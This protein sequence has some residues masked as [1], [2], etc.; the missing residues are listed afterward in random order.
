MKIILLI[1]AYIFIGCLVTFA[2]SKTEWF[3]DIEFAGNAE[4]LVCVGM[5]VLLWPGFAWA[6]VFY[7]F[8]TV[9]GATC[10]IIAGFMDSF[11]RK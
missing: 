6:I 7:A 3:D 9:V 11:K 10:T 1:L 8:I 5:Y 4:D 2:V